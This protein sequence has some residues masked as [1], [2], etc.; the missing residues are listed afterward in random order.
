MRRLSPFVMVMSI[1]ILLGATACGQ[2]ASSS[3]PL[4]DA[5]SAPPA[6]ETPSPAA[7]DATPS[8]PAGEATPDTSVEQAAPAAPAV[9]L[10][11]LSGIVTIEG[12]ETITPALQAAADAFVAQAP[13]V[14]VQ[15]ATTTSGKGIRRLCKGDADIV[16]SSRVPTGAEEQ[17][18]ANH[19]VAYDEYEVAREA[20]AVIVNP[21]NDFAACLT[22]DALQ[23]AW[24]PG[25]QVKTW[26]DLDPSWP[27][28]PI[29][30]VGRRAD[31][32]A[33]LFFTQVVVGEEGAVR[34]DYKVFDSHDEIADAV[35]K[36]DNA[37]GFLPFPDFEKNTDRVKLAAI[38]AGE[39]CV[40]P[41][42]G[43]IRDG[44]YSP[45]VQPQFV[46]VNRA[47]L[48]RP[49]VTAFLRIYFADAADIGGATGVSPTSDDV[50]AA[51][52]NELEAA[53]AGTDE[54]DGP[55]A[56]PEPKK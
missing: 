11:G 18:C 12:S 7:Q 46:Y 54:K 28:D 29:A 34:D 39:G 27:A 45:L 47:S 6:E 4:Q 31:S 52:V 44:A 9:D 37:L 25:S 10:S 19:E 5:T 13:D 35:S 40:T 16:A 24:E 56:T 14:E 2:T 43:T 23:R 3:P 49:E 32:G 1:V 51:N 30:L 22:V 48:A 21:A 36:D 26:Q 50:Y 33:V 42:A 20:I 55:S 15:V 41:S 38:D 53:I 8:S 17:D